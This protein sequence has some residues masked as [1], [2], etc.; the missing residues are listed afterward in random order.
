MSR[1]YFSSKG[2]IPWYEKQV[3]CGA[4]RV[5][6]VIVCLGML[7]L[8]Y[9][10]GSDRQRHIKI[11]LSFAPRGVRLRAGSRW[12][13]LPLVAAVL[14]PVVASAQGA[15]EELG[16]K[17]TGSKRTA[18]L[19]EMRTLPS[20]LRPE[21]VGVHPRVYFTGEELDKLK[22]KAHGPDRAMWQ[23]VL[24]NL[25]V[26]QGP[27]PLPPAEKRRA[28]NDVALAI[29][30]G[31]F[32]YRIEGDPKILAATKLYMDAA[33]SY[34]V[35]G[36]AF[37]KP[38]TDLAAG[39]LLYGLGLGYDLLYNDLTPAERERYRNKLAKQGA[40]MYAAFAPK[41]GRSWA[42]SQNHTFIPIAGLAV[43]AYAVYGEVPEA[44]QWA[45]LSRAIFGRVLATYSQD[46]YYY[47][48]YEYWIFAT[49]W[50]VHYLDAQKHA[51]GEDLFDQPG[52]RLM[53]LYAA[54]SLVPGGQTMFDF[55]DVFNGPETRAL[56]G[57]DYERSHPVSGGRAHF[58]TNYNLLYDLAGRLQ[59]TEIQGV[60]D[61]M[62]SL[63]HTSQEE[64]W[65][66]AWRDDALGSMP[67]AKLPRWHLFADHQV[68]YWRSDWGAGATAVAYKCGPPEGTSAEAVLAKYPDWHME[69]GH[70]HPDVN[71]FILYAHN[72]YL[73]GTSGYAGVP[74]TAEANTLLVDG[75]GQGHEGHG[76]DAWEGMDYSQLAKIHIVSARFSKSG[77]DLVGEGAPAYDAGLGVTHD[78]RHLWM[79]K[80]GEMHV[81]DELEFAAPRHFSE[82]LHT[83]TSFKSLDYEYFTSGVGDRTLGVMFHSTVAGSAKIE[84]N[85]VMGPGRPGS[86][87]KGTLEQRGEKLVFSSEEAAKSANF[88]WLLRF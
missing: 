76:H 32:A 53:D 80:A 39:H 67:I 87:D 75:T 31:A 66:L 45:A 6:F 12:Q 86:V 19:E 8:T 68:A 54:H 5:G 44:K 16:A 74:K 29:A 85:I 57:E 77:F 25:R 35:W 84:P 40:L 2:F 26:L 65:T 78:L 50:I 55:G 15:G 82:V 70:A 79:D 9:P 64:W 43:A 10:V 36:Y 69:A 37:S 20:S 28:Q 18:L 1:T 23:G 49:P 81:K 41:P 47:E 88:E 24:A 21:L 4:I 11:S 34:D 61:W 30:E 63:G 51:T 13:L 73:T 62:K 27:P 59:S 71:A 38:N 60:A 56:K 83:D 52:L 17:D 14:L 22:I 58:E 3:A 72:Q 42:Y 48:G 7:S 33:V 46:G